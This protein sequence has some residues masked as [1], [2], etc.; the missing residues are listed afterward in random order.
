MNNS[1]YGQMMMNER[2]L[3]MENSY[4]GQRKL[5][6]ITYRNEKSLFQTQN[7]LIITILI[8]N[9]NLLLDIK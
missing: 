2:E 7:T 9:M 4:Q 3:N 5:E 1:C 8:I 6:D